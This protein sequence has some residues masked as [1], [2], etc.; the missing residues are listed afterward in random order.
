MICKGSPV[1]KRFNRGRLFGTMK[2]KS[3]EKTG[4]FFFTSIRWLGFEL[5][6]AT[7]YL[8]PSAPEGD[9]YSV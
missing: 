8:E 7:Y 6:L 4:F 3:D 1:V 9:K 2:S 5:L